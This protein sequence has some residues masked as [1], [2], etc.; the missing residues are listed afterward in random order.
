MRK[1]FRLG[2]ASVMLLTLVAVGL[3]VETSGG[4]SSA[5]QM[6]KAVGAQSNGQGQPQNCN[7]RIVSGR[8]AYDIQG[9]I[10]APPPVTPAA[11][12]GVADFDGMGSLTISDIASFAGTVVPRTGS[13]TYSVQPDCTATLSLTILTGFP[14]GTIFHLHGVI[15]G[16]GE[17]IKFIQTDQGTMFTGTAERQ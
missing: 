9:T 15:I 10:I 3:A 5:W 1:T 7:N 16:R 4:K 14:L 11:A 8:Y 6:I 13:G 12:V 2:I 17:E